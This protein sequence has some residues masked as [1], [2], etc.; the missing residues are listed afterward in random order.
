MI[1][2]HN[3]QVEP[4]KQIT[5]GNVTVTNSTDNVYRYTDDTKDTYDTITEK[6]INRLGGE[7]CV[8]LESDGLY[9]DYMPE[10]AEHSNQV[11]KLSSNL[12]SLSQKTDPSKVITVLKPLGKAAERTTTGT[13][14]ETDTATSTPRLTISSVN[15]GSP[16][17]TDSNLVNQFGIH[18]VSQTWD[19]VTTAT[20]L[21]SKGDAVLASQS[22]V[23]ETLQLNAVDLSLVGVAVDDID[24][25]NYYRVVNPLMAYDKEPRVVGQELDICAPENST[26]TAGD[27][28]LSQE[29]Y[30]LQ[31]IDQAEQA[32]LTA[33]Y[34]KSIIDG[35]DTQ[36]SEISKEVDALKNSTGS[37][38]VSY[39]EGNI[40]DVSEFQGS[41]N[42]SSVVGAGLALAVIRVQS[43]SDHEDLAYKTNIP[44]AISAGANYG[45]YAY[46]NGL[47]VTDSETEATN[48]YNRSQAVVG[49]NRKPRLYMIDV[50]SNTVTSGTL[51]ASVNAYLNTLNALGVPDSQIVIYV[52]NALYESIDTTRTQIWIPSYGTNDGSIASS[53]K[54]LYPYDLWQYT[55]QGHVAGITANTVDMSTDPS[56][57]FKSAFLTK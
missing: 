13:T 28:A 38:E 45:V 47:S 48:F 56:A 16:F 4:Y 54:P 22:P 57:R 7:I 42:W 32:Q 39:Y 50:E 20:V 40:I 21:K 19:D 1:D 9:L 55:S 12:M 11:I 53:I 34:Y 36:L 24:C 51:S 17:L 52:S 15:N 37:G 5:L 6:L 8:R 23:S 46:F 49:S 33:D 35:Y 27:A 14:G 41:I 31:L 2:Q 30:T 44:A 25:G 29:S 10:I 3:Q 26:L 18:V 43:G